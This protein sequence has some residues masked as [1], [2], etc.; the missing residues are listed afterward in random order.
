MQ[1]LSCTL[2]NIEIKTSGE[3]LS[4]C[5]MSKQMSH[6]NSGDIVNCE[7]FGEF[8]AHTQANAK[9]RKTSNMEIIPL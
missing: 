2:R 1:Q 3:G 5:L 8:R 6:D 4:V 9:E 7:Q